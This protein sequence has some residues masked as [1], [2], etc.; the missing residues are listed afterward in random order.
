[1]R[2]QIYRDLFCWGP[3]PLSILCKFMVTISVAQEHTGKGNRNL[4]R[5]YV[6][7]VPHIL[8]F[9]SW[10]IAQH[11]QD[12]RDSVRLWWPTC[13]IGM[14]WLH[15]SRFWIQ[16]N[17]QWNCNSSPGKRMTKFDDWFI[18]KHRQYEMI[19]ANVISCEYYDIEPMNVVNEEP[20]WPVVMRN[21]IFVRLKWITMDRTGFS[22][23]TKSLF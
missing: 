22:W 15:C 2:E 16:W 5:V 12:S 18:Q 10:A 8:H 20:D 17:L 21:Y 7:I 9:I 11:D 13:K 19:S 1:M 23:I 6:T 4:F 14:L 3:V